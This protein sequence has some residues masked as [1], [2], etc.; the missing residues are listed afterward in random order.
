M[1][2]NAV[3]I[4]CPSE[5]IPSVLGEKKRKK[6]ENHQMPPTTCCNNK[7]EIPSLSAFTL[8]NV[9]SNWTLAA[10][11]LN[12]LLC[13]SN[14]L[15]KSPIGSTTLVV[16]AVVGG[17]PKKFIVPWPVAHCFKVQFLWTGGKGRLRTLDSDGKLDIQR[18]VSRIMLYVSLCAIQSRTL[19]LLRKVWMTSGR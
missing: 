10:K 14:F 4:I 12:P 18:R 16:V 19:L 9:A 7:Y 11:A 1:I 6:K 3:I 13:I 2:K 5:S 8:S 15:I 17:Y